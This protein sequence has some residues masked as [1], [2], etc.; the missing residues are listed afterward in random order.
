VSENTMTIAATVDS[1]H[2][3]WLSIAHADIK[4]D[5]GV[6]G[7]YDTREK[8]NVAAREAVAHVTR[9]VQAQKQRLLAQMIDV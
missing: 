6:Y 3:V 9:Q 8:A 5:L 2:K 4:T 7:P 1:E